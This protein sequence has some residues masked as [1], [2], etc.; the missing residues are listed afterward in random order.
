MKCNP[1]Q[2]YPLLDAFVNGQQKTFP[3]RIQDKQLFSTFPSIET[4]KK[5]YN[6]E[7]ERRSFSI[8]NFLQFQKRERNHLKDC[9][10]EV[11]IS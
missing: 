6:V 7:I 9:S 11:E 8:F 2:N 1:S 3:H 4:I 5:S 10:F